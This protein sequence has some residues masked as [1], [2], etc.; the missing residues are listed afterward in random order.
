MCVRFEVGDGARDGALNGT[1][2]SDDELAE[3]CAFDFPAEL[4]ISL[5][6]LPGAHARRAARAVHSSQCVVGA[7]GAPLRRGRRTAC[8]AGTLLAH[9]LID[10]PCGPRGLLG[11]RRGLQFAPYLLSAAAGLL[12]G[13]KMSRHAVI[14]AAVVV[15]CMLATASSATYVAAPE[16]YPTPVRSTGS[17]LAYWLTLLGGVASAPWVYSGYSRFTIAAVLAACNLL[18]A[19]IVL[20]LPETAGPMGE[21]GG[22]GAAEGEAAAG[23]LGVAA[24]PAVLEVPNEGEDVSLIASSS[25]AARHGTFQDA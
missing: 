10:Y 11:G 9:L 24:E 3:T 17:N 1:D 13:V 6:E 7:C 15:R 2:V 22:A 16:L 25:P 14:G 20:A 8:A 19:L 4:I 23:D 18:T 21:H 5:A 12:T